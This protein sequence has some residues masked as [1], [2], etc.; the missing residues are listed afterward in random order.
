[1]TVT[2]SAPSE[3]VQRDRAVGAVL[4]SAAGDA[5]GAPHE[6]GPP[7]GADVD[8]EMTGGGQLGWE[9]SEWTDDTQTTLAILRPLA[10]GVVPDQ[11]LG[12][13]EEGL[14]AWMRS[15]PRDVG[16]QT[17][18][19]LSEALRTGESLTEVTAVWKRHHPDTAG[20]GSLMRTG[21]LGLLGLPR[22]NLAE[23]AGS[24]SALTHAADDAVE[25]C[26]LWTDAIHRSI[27][28]PTTA[29]SGQGWFDLV[30]EG[31]TLLPSDHRA[32]WR[33]R[34]EA[35]VTSSPEAFRPNGWVVSALQAALS[36]LIHTDVPTEQSC[37][38][39][40]L[41][42]E[43]AVR[44]GD[45]TDTV[46]AITGSLAGA[47]WGATA[48]PFEWR[49]GLHGRRTYGEPALRGT[50]LEGLARLAN[51]NGLNDPIGWP[52]ID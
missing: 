49:R 25:A 4:A 51:N 9:P 21:P 5:L 31:I 41:A 34:L 17:R 43:R 46:A 1:M 12:D 32:L 30:A 52:G 47:C 50:D 29:L 40:R 8:L 27:H 28:G 15:R 36:S 42:I 13:V 18:A 11:L 7:L 39:L 38:H 16:G 2:S 24:I 10:D 19:V 44:I 14:L 35:C 33:S 23:L 22:E 48:V 20:N 37:R 26:I 6:F 3:N 45:D